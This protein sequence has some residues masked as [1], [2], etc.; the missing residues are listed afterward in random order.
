[1][2][3]RVFACVRARACLCLRLSECAARVYTMQLVVA[4][5]Y[6]YTP[7]NVHKIPIATVLFGLTP[8]T[9]LVKA[10]V[11]MGKAVGSGEPGLGWHQR[12]ACA[13]PLS[14]LLPLPLSLS[15]LLACLLGS[16]VSLCFALARSLSPPALSLSLS[17]PLGV[18]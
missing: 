7:E 11:D 6:P 12:S 14:V 2:C 16:E 1:M 4:F 15:L 13:A 8:W 9:L 10:I 18:C 17:L 3:V 5:G